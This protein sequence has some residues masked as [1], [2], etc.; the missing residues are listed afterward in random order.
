MDR[1]I[2]CALQVDG[3]ASWR[4]IADVLGES[5]RTVTRR[6]T[7]LLGDRAVVIAARPRARGN[8]IVGAHCELGQSRIVARALTQ[9]SDSFLVHI[10][11]GSPDCVV[12][13]DSPRT[14]LNNL[15]FEELPGVRGIVKTTTQPVLRPTHTISRWRPDVLTDNEV[16]A[17]LGEHRV[18]NVDVASGRTEVD[19][20]DDLLMKALALDGRRSIEELSR[21]C[22]LSD[23]TV[24]RR[25]E[26]LRR[27]GDV[28]IRAIVEPALL[29]L[30][31]EAVLWV[32][33]RPTYVE[34]VADALGHSPSVRYVSVMVGDR[35][36]MATV[37]MPSEEALYEF[38]THGS[39]LENVNSVETAMVLETYKRGGAPTSM[40]N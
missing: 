12:I 29:G 23:T 1:R 5:E 26:K 33:A 6:G 7:K 37:S 8:T 16:N 28:I 34:A 22:G 4:F 35:Q 38:V 9:R 27:D 25:I 30:P 40:V 39:W 17:L 19:R 18:Q 10:L 20:V 21:L 31:V 13:L 32:S 3:R 36:I 2:A 15:V 24:R 11:T 14:H